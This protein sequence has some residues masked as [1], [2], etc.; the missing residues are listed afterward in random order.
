MNLKRTLSLLLCLA[1][2]LGMFATCGA[3]GG[4]GG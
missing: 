1:F 3:A 4:R 2:A